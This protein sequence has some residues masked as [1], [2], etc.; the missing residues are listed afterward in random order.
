MIPSLKTLG[1]DY[2]RVHTV[3]FDFVDR[4]SERFHEVKHPCTGER[5]TVLL[6]SR[7]E[8]VGA[9]FSFCQGRTVWIDAK[10][11]DYR[12]ARLLWK[13]LLILETA[14]T[15]IY[16]HDE[17]GLLMYDFITQKRTNFYAKPSA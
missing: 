5:L 6:E 17:H 14:T 10:P 1:S 7:D 8:I 3:A 12:R 4:A 9:D 13:E 16:T 2:W 11:I 15:E